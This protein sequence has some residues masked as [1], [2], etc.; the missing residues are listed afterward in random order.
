M[1]RELD[2]H[3][4][5]AS[6]RRSFSARSSS[7]STASADT[8]RPGLA[9]VNAA[10]AA[11][12]ANARNRTITDTSTPY[13]RAASA[14]EISCEVTSRNTSHFSSDESCLR[15]LRLPLSIITTS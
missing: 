13:F 9:E 2:R 11:S 8:G 15:D 14:C 10:I 5:S 3:S 1:Q 12:F 7:S 6:Q 4:F